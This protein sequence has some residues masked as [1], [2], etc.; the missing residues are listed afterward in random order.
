MVWWDLIDHPLHAVLKHHPLYHTPMGETAK[1]L[2]I[3]ASTM[4][5]YNHG[6]NEKICLPRCGRDTGRSNGINACVATATKYMST[7]SGI[8]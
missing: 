6:C 5:S 4:I 1:A 2:D 8:I 7:K 3:A